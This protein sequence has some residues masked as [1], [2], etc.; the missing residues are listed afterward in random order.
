MPSNKYFKTNNSTKCVLNSSINN[1]THYLNPKRVLQ[2][3]ENLLFSNAQLTPNLNATTAT[4]DS[5][6]I[7]LATQN[8]PTVFTTISSLTDLPAH[9]I[10]I[11]TTI[12]PLSTNS[13]LSSM[14]KKRKKRYKKPIELRKILPKNSLMLLH[15][16][17]PNVE[18]RFL[19]QSGPIHRPI[20]TMCVDISEH[21]FEGVGKTKKEARMMAAEKTL[22]F[23]M[24]FPDYIQKYR[25]NKSSNSTSSSVNKSLSPKVNDDDGDINSDSNQES[26]DNN[27]E[28]EELKHKIVKINQNDDENVN[29]SEVTD[30]VKT[31]DE[32]LNAITV[33]HDVNN[34]NDVK[35]STEFSHESNQT[36]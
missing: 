2:Q 35:I 9:T 3:Q 13:Q 16:L 6:N 11:G 17:I 26:V 19:K 34:N 33:E 36:S 28:D 12:Q 30:V 22:K 8:T 25:A 20:F 21:S 23:L 31:S 15:E 27:G 14:N 10:P 1:Q 32:N 5:T 18:Y 24:E 4:S 29:N 7:Y